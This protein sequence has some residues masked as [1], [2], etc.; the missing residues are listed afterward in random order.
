MEFPDEVDTPCDVPVREKFAGYRGLNSFRTSPWIGAKYE[1]PEAYSALYRISHPREVEKVVLE[2]QARGIDCAMPGQY[3]VVVLRECSFKG[4]GGE[5][6]TTNTL[7]GVMGLYANQA[8]VTCFGLLRHETKM[9]LCHFRVK[10]HPVFSAPVD[11]EGNPL[12]DTENEYL[13]KSGDPLVI[14]YGFRRVLAF[15]T[16][17]EHLSDPKQDKAKMVRFFHEGMNLVLSAVCPVALTRPNV[18]IFKPVDPEQCPEAAGAPLRLVATGTGLPPN[19]D[20]LIIKRVVLT[21][22]PLKVSK[23]TA[24]VR[25]MF[26]NRTD[27]KWYRPIELQTK[28]G[29]TGHITQPVG[30]HGLLKA[31]FDKPLHQGDTVMLKLYKR[32]FPDAASTLPFGVSTLEACGNAMT[33]YLDKEEDAREEERAR[34]EGQEKDIVDMAITAYTPFHCTQVHL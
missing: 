2:E 30:L 7:E 31:R 1:L 27:I 28:Y 26:F 17:S 24:W 34:I 9:S 3:V 4:M 29:R 6:Q 5:D 22:Y 10:R 21:G 33:A 12:P 19:V 14:Q 13:I 16:I 15:P 23:I 11:E 18:L 25:Y 20:K 32:T 8:P